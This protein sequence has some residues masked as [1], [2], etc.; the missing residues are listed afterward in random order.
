MAPI[1]KKLLILFLITF[2]AVSLCSAQSPPSPP[3]STSQLTFPLFTLN[4]TPV[5]SYSAQLVGNPG[6]GTYFYWF[7]ANFPVGST[8]PSGPLQVTGAPN[9]LSGSN[10]IQ[11]NFVSPVGASSVDVLRTTSS[12]PPT[13]ACNCAVSVGATSS[14]VN[15]QSNS[16]NGYTVTP[17]DPNTLALT[18]QNEVNGPGS[19]HLILRQVPASPGQLGA[20]VAD[21]SNPSA[22]SGNVNAPVALTPNQLPKATAPATLADSPFADDGAGNGT[23]S[24]AGGFN[25]TAGPV[26]SGSPPVSCGAAKGCFA[27]R[28][29]N[30]AG[31]PTGGESYMR[32]DS[33][34]NAPKCSFNGGAEQPCNPLLLGDLCGTPAAPHVCGLHIMT[35]VGDMITGGVLGAP[36]VLPGPTG[37][38]G[39]PQTLT[40]TPSGG[41]AVAET[42]NLAGVPIRAS[43]CTANADTILATDRAGLVNET[44]NAA[45]CTVTIPQ[46]GSTNFGSNFVFVLRCAG[47]QS[48][49]LTPTTSTIN[50]GATL[51]V[52]NG[53]SAFVYSDNTNYFA[54][55]VDAASLPAS[56]TLLA[57][58]SS[59]GPIA[60]VL[61]SGQFY[62]G[63]GSNLP[64]GV[65]ISGDFTCTNAGVCTVTALNG[66]AVPVSATVLGTNGSNQPIVAP[67][68]SGKVWFGSAGNLPVAITI[69]G[70]FTCTNAGVCTISAINGTTVPALAKVLGTNAGSQPIA[71]TLHGNSTQVQ[72][73]DGTGASGNVAKFDANGNVV[74]GGVAA[75][76]IVNASSPGAGIGRFAG[77]TQTETSS[78]LSGDCATSGSNAVTCTQINGNKDAISNAGIFTKYNNI[79][80]V[81]S[82]V[83]SEVVKIDTTGL[84]ANVGSTTLYAVPTTQMLRVSASLVETVAG[85]VSSTLP[86]LKVS[87]TDPDTA[88][89]VVTPV[90]STNSANT[91]GTP[92][93]GVAVMRST[94]STCTYQTAGYAS[95]LAGM[96]YALHIVVEAQ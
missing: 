30:T 75:A 41:A 31:T 33:T 13:G 53:N 4:L 60:A 59:R 81:N 16:L 94:A 36:V 88:G 2:L 51:T 58:N 95:S 17:F 8:A 89:T 62:V 20:K 3:V 25:A 50:G 92:G 93:T 7:V 54:V 32:M 76:N 27:G 70:D 46:A 71:A 87:C 26:S 48:C 37:P 83:W 29:S 56:A 67:L 19:A 47:T 24:G 55:P 84:T 40:D 22:G 10:Y 82:G 11:V 96:T 18:L 61:N 21:L 28:Q 74:D 38:N 45:S 23:Y 12:T 77:G 80:L 49:V 1:M 14:P 44:D 78:E 39:V 68:A 65:T 64:V 79:S 72:L 69:S 57:T 52:V 6:P 42:W 5:T 63:N 43:T 73:S 34:T 90:T 86:N 85:S 9:L 91:V 66:T 15:D 35:L